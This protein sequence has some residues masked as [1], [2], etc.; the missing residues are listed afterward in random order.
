MLVAAAGAVMAEPVAVVSTIAVGLGNY[1]SFIAVSFASLPFGPVS[2]ASEGSIALIAG[3]YGVLF[4]L[5]HRRT[6]G[7]RLWRM[8]GVIRSAGIGRPGVTNPAMN[9]R[10]SRYTLAIIAVWLVAAASLAGFVLTDTST[11]DLTVT[12]FETNRGDM[13]LGETPSGT[14]LLIDGGDDSDLAVQNLEAA[15]PAHANDFDPSSLRSARSDARP[16]GGP[17]SESLDP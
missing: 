16:F 12:F 3:W 4:I 14:R 8:A 13:I 11:R 15:L 17:A 2:A 9:P 6:V 1:M 10:K 7:A 5:L